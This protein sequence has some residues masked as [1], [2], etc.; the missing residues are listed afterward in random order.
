MTKTRHAD[1]K[2]PADIEADYRNASFVAGNRVI[3]NIKGN[4]YRLVAAVN[5]G[6]G[7]VYVRFAFTHGE[8]DAIDAKTI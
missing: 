3:S 4:H 2:T 8:Y 1:W 6:F 7:I 5:Y